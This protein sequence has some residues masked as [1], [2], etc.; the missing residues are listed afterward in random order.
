MHYD[1]TAKSWCQFFQA[2]ASGQKTHDLRDMKDRNYK[3][4]DVIR[5]EEFDPVSGEYTGAI[6][7]V[8]IT[9]I[10]SKN[11]PCAFSSAVLDSEYCILSLS[12]MVEVSQ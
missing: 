3:V 5:L 6:C 8:E 9:Y 10:T 12:L 7:Y 4:G 2:I 11:T 1:H